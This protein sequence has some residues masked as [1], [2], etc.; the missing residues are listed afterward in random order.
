MTMGTKQAITKTPVTP[1]ELRR[2]VVMAWEEV[3]KRLAR[4]Q[5]SLTDP[6]VTQQFIHYE[7]PLKQQA[8]LLMSQWGAEQ[9]GG[10]MGQ[11]QLAAC[12]TEGRPPVPG[13]S[14]GP[15]SAERQLTAPPR[16]RRR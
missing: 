12:R 3:T 1:I 9:G 10:R 7:P 16:T 13:L 2:H 8:A 11:R 6:T 14:P 4:T 15:H 5:M